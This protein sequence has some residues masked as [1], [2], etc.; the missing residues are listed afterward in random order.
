MKI[1]L[2]TPEEKSLPWFDNTRLT[3]LNTCPTWGTV[4]YLH[5]RTFPKGGR[6]M[7]LEAGKAMHD[8]FAAIRLLDLVENGEEFYRVKP[9][10]HFD[11]DAVHRH[12][13]RTFGVDRW[14]EV[15]GVFGTGDDL[16]TRLTRAAI[17]ALASSGFYDDPSDR[18][19]TL[20]NL[21]EAAFV[22]IDRYRFGST[23]PVV[24]GDFVGVEV[25]FDVIIET[26]T[27][28]RRFVGKVDGLCFDSDG[29][30][31]EPHENKTASRLDDAWHMSFIMSHQV[32]GYCIAL[33]P[34]LSALG[35]PQTLSQA[36][37]YGLC[38]PVP[39]SAD[40]GGYSR[41]P[42]ERN[43]FQKENWLKWFEYTTSQ[44]DQWVADPHNAPMFTHSCNRYFRSCPLV[45]YCYAGQEERAEIF[46]DMEVN[47][48][49][50]LEEG[51]E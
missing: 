30:I 44:S 20:T 24:V 40:Y 26:S 15:C 9:E 25:P 18:R 11:I 21:E 4:R 14:Q 5:N 32:T 13:H 28:P 38:I 47:E 10:Y 42:V 29:V 17:V 45:P 12:A 49:H 41:H 6:A 7:P 37:M 3:A 8:V 31:V 1:R 43:N 35:V 36:V 22:Y 27:G 2:T 50:P 19:R 46:N 16:R 23:I 33:E 39:R 34:V 51:N 48:W